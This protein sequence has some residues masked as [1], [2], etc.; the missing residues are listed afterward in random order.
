MKLLKHLFKGS[1]ALFTLFFNAGFFYY[2]YQLF[3]HIEEFYTLEGTIIG[4]SLTLLIYGMY[5]AYVIKTYREKL[6]WEKEE[7]DKK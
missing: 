1:L 4:T 7:K 6:K 2:F 3:F 5:W